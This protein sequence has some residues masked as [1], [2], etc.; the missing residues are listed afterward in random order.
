MNQGRP[1]VERDDPHS[2]GAE[3]VLQGGDLGLNPAGDLQGVLADPHQDHTADRLLAVLFQ[4]RAAEPLADLDRGELTHG[5]RRAVAHGDDGALVEQL[6]LAGV[7]SARIVD[8]S[9]PA[10]ADADW[11]SIDYLVDTESLRAQ[12]ATGVGASTAVASSV[13]VA[14]FDGA[15]IRAVAE[16]SGKVQVL[17]NTN[18]EDQ[19]QVNAR[20]MAQLLA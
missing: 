2:L 3:P 19:G 17:F 6:F 13:P 7:A 1:I 11:R 12:L 5:D 8:A 4:D 9:S 16:R 20:L 18:M 14:A 15:E 10:A